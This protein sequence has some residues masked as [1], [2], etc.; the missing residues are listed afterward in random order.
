MEFLL[1]GGVMISF[2]LPLRRKTDLRE[3]G[4][5]TEGKVYLQGLMGNPKKYRE[6]ILYRQKK[7]NK[8]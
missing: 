6:N 5:M 1:G 2:F 3:R 4:R 8:C 7:K